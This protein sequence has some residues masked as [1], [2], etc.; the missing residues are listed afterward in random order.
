MGKQNSRINLKPE[1]N[2]SAYQSSKEDVGEH[3]SKH[4]LE[5]TK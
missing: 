1:F 5:S 2:E 3:N 4:K